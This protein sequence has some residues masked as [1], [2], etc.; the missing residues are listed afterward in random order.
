M[1]EESKGSTARVWIVA[2]AIAAGIAFV[3][4][5]AMK[6]WGGLNFYIAPTQLMG[7]LSPL[8]LTAAFIERAVEVA[9]SPWRDAEA[10]ARQA[11]LDRVKAAADAD[12]ETL[13]SA[14]KSLRD[15]RG[16]TQQY[17]FAVALLL[18]AAASAAGVRAL[19]PLL[20]AP[21][22]GGIGGGQQAAFDLVDMTL[23]AIMLAGGAAGI[24]SVVTAFT[25]Y[26]DATG[27]KARKSAAS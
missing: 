13:K 10:D 5:A 14:R 3:A 17:A 19:W 20:S 11:E 15:Y 21:K 26:F 27:E 2:L 7:T 25:S 4:C 16:K 9:I 12:P 8:L 18:G 23:S 6:Q 24:H 22:L 1:N